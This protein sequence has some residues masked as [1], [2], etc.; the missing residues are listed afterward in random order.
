M[1]FLH[2]IAL[3][4]VFIISGVRSG[5][6]RVAVGAEDLEL[7]EGCL[8]VLFSSFFFFLGGQSC[9]GEGMLA[10]CVPRVSLSSTLAFCCCRLLDYTTTCL[11]RY[12]CFGDSFTWSGRRGGILAAGD[13]ELRRGTAFFR[14]CA[15]LHQAFGDGA[16]GRRFLTFGFWLEV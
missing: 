14:G 3:V 5:V 8:R 16:W 1:V 15:N 13:A 12:S 2:E 9:V 7:V 10:V 6:F 4:H 11:L